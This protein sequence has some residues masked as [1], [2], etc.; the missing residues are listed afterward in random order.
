[1][2]DPMQLD[3]RRVS[4]VRNCMTRTQRGTG[5]QSLDLRAGGPRGNGALFSE[6]WRKTRSHFEMAASRGFSASH[7][8]TRP[9]NMNVEKGIG[10]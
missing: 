5:E 10:L 2:F 1:M 4:P 7:E 9:W 3:E 6:S 8:R